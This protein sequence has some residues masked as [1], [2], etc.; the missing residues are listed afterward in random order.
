M[1]IQMG[2]TV[3]DIFR[4]EGTADC[5]RVLFFLLLAAKLRK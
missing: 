2:S 4:L 3:F 1:H 5:R